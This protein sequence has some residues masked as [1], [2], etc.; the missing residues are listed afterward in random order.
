MP[1]FI[2]IGWIKTYIDM[3]NLSCKRRHVNGKNCDGDLQEA[4]RVGADGLNLRDRALVKE[5][6]SKYYVDL[7][8]DEA[9]LWKWRY[10][11]NGIVDSAQQDSFSVGAE[12]PVE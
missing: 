6:T 2:R 12:D 10:E 7:L 8:L 4:E 1:P 11:S 9:G 5:A 3:L